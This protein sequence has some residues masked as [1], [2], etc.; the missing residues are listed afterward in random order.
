MRQ[1]V[2]VRVLL[3][4]VSNES[5]RFLSRNISDDPSFQSLAKGYM[6]TR[7]GL[8]RIATRGWKVTSPPAKLVTLS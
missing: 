8:T 6:H 3:E 5:Y 7:D 2:H 1:N 4:R